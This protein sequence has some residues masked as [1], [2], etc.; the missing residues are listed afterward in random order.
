MSVIARS[1]TEF[2]ARVVSLEGIL[3]KTP[4]RFADVGMPEIAA[5]II[6]AT[7]GIDPFRDSQVRWVRASASPLRRLMAGPRGL[8]GEGRAIELPYRA[9]DRK[10]INLAIRQLRKQSVLFVLQEAR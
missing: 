5:H 9:G 6:A 10:K 4:L 3:G 1:D 7:I 8:I 2:A